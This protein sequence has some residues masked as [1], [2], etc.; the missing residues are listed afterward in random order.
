LPDSEHFTIIVDFVIEGFYGMARQYYIGAL[1][2]DLTRL[3]DTDD[4]YPVV[5]LSN[6]RF[7]FVGMGELRIQT[8]GEASVLLDENVLG[9]T[10]N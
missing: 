1:G 5:W 9:L 7:L 3:T 4:A 8:V 6:E 10:Q 2:E